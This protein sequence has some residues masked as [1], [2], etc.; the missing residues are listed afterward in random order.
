MS[1]LDERAITEDERAAV[2]DEARPGVWFEENIEPQ[3]NLRPLRGDAQPLDQEQTDALIVGELSRRDGGARLAE[4][5][6]IAQVWLTNPSPIFMGEQRRDRDVAFQQRGG[7]HSDPLVRLYAFRAW[8]NR[9]RA[10]FDVDGE[11]QVRRHYGFESIEIDVTSED[12]VFTARAKGSFVQRG[13]PMWVPAEA[14]FYDG[15]RDALARM[16]EAIRLPTV[17][18]GLP[19]A[20]LFR[21]VAEQIQRNRALHYEAPPED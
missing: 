19:D 20:V 12:F 13:A 16:A 17:T 3:L 8:E 15:F 9:D 14:N 10:W 6:Q 2:A 21:W 5:R 18:T 1:I 7:I 11:Q 4:V